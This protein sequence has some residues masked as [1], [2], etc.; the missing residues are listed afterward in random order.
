MMEHEREVVKLCISGKHVM[1][2]A[3]WV[4]KI[5]VYLIWEF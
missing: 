3:M 1:L 5:S 2:L 4:S